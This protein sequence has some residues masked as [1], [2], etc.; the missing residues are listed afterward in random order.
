MLQEGKSK[1]GKSKEV[2]KLLPLKEPKP[3]AHVRMC[4][5]TPIEKSTQRTPAKTLCASRK[6]PAA[7]SGNFAARGISSWEHRS[8]M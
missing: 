3:V 2:K 1:E 5:P 8:S 6:G 7:K 4:A